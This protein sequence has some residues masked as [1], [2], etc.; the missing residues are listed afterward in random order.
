MTSQRVKNKKLRDQTKSSGVAVV[1]YTLWRLLRSITEHTHT[2]KCYLFVLHNEN[3]NGLLKDFWGIKKEKQVRW[4]D[5]TWIDAI[6]VCDHGQQPMKMH[7]E[8]TLLYK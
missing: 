4:R 3:S 1:L 6:C 2:E 5:L 7:T 8:V